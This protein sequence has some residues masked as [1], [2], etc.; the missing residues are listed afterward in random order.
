[1]YRGSKKSCLSRSMYVFFILLVCD[2]IIVNHVTVHLRTEKLRI[3]GGSTKSSHYRRIFGL[4]VVH[5]QKGQ[6]TENTHKK[7]PMHYGNLPRRK[8][9]GTGTGCGRRFRFILTVPPVYW[10]A[11]PYT[12]PTGVLKKTPRLLI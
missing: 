9:Y 3:F 10:Y 8:R 5:T 1:M 12:I 2:C 11:R 4:P 7:N 6:R